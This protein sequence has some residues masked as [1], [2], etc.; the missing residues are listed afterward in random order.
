MAGWAAGER[1]TSLQAHVSRLRR[2]FGDDQRI[3][4]TGGGYLVRVAPGE[5]DRERFERLVEE[6]GMAIATEDWRLASGK[7]R[8]ALGLWRGAPLS[9]FQ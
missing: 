5:L 4:T 1:A 2:A 8:E 9:E 6:G 7:L 3:V